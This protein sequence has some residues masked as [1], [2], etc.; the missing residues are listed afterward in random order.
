[1]D[2]SGLVMGMAPAAAGL[3]LRGV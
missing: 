3:I 2:P 1:M